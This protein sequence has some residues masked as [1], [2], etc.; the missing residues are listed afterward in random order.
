MHNKKLETNRATSVMSKRN[1]N[2]PGYKK[3]KVGWIPE[4][5]ELRPVKKFGKAIKGNTPP[6]NDD[7]NY[8]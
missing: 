7:R 1:E 6:K 2:R 4:E 3:T 8:G 5:W